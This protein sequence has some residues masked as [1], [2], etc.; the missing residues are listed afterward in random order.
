MGTSRGS[1]RV[2]LC[3][4]ACLASAAPVAAAASGDAPALDASTVMGIVSAVVLVSVGFEKLE[5]VAKHLSSSHNQPVVAAL[6]RE[7]TVLGT[8]TLAAWV[9]QCGR[10]VTWAS[11]TRRAPLVVRTWITR[12]C[13]TSSVPCGGYRATR[14]RARPAVRQGR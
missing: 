7:L 14:C 6:F 10:L 3:L 8:P 11:L 4:G 5:H 12:L 2:W 1:R 9:P 13:R